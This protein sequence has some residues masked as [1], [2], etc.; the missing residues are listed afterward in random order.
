MKLKTKL[1]IVYYISGFGILMFGIMCYISPSKY[2]IVASTAL[3]LLYW[4]VAEDVCINE[5]KQ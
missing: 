2:D 3:T 4:Y 1:K 5:S